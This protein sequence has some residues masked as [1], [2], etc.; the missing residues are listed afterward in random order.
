MSIVAAWEDPQV[1]PF[2]I[3]SWTVIIQQRIPFSIHKHIWDI[4]RKHLKMGVPE[5]D[6]TGREKD[7][8]RSH[9][10]PSTCYSPSW[11]FSRERLWGAAP[12]RQTRPEGQDTV[13][14]PGWLAHIVVGPRVRGRETCKKICGTPKP[15]S[16]DQRILQL[17]NVPTPSHCGTPSS[18]ILFLQVAKGL[19]NTLQ[20]KWSVHIAAKPRR[21]SRTRDTWIHSPPTTPIVAHLSSSRWVNSEQPCLR[22]VAPGKHRKYIACLSHPWG[23]YPETEVTRSKRGCLSSGRTPS[24]FHS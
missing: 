12:T 20:S 7:R 2:E 21:K 5:P 17:G 15:A 18:K 9:M 11:H 4:T 3:T 14:Q 19:K 13:I 8:E 10:Q 24:V 22:K 6:E 23:W 16:I 1:S